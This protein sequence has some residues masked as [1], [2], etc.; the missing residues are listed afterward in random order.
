MSRRFQI[1]LPG[2]A[3][4][5]FRHTGR[6][7]PSSSLVHAMAALAC[8]AES[9]FATIARAADARVGDRLVADDGTVA[10]E[11]LHVTESVSPPI[12]VCAF[13]GRGVDPMPLSSFAYET[14][15]ETH[16]KNRH[17]FH[18]IEEDEE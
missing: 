10:V 17:R 9:M 5:S 3:A 7:L 2:N 6:G 16:L 15:I 11:V 4:V 8:A 1:D 13:P 18:A 12:V 14:L